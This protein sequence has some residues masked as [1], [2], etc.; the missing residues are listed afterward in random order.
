MV[1]TQADPLEFRQLME[2]YEAAND[3]L[4]QKDFFPDSHQG[5]FP[6]PEMVKQAMEEGVQF[7]GIEDGRY[8]CAYILDHRCDPSYRSAPWRVEA[9]EGEYV[10]LHALRVLPDYVGNGFSKK[11]IDHALDTA[12]SWGQKAVRLDVMEG[13]GAE[14]L[15]CACGFV[16]VD[17]VE[18]TYPD[19]GLP[20][21]FRLLERA[22]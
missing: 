20:I 12:R 15:Y 13:N 4:H 1:I 18:I 19:I 9:A 5:V 21:R 6:P 10:V 16:P 22:L 3:A 7:V 14:G 17:T 2:L 8:V 11:L